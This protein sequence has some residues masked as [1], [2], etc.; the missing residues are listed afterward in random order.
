MTHATFSLTPFPD[1]KLPDI[2]ITG[3][4]LRQR[5]LIE[6]HY[7]VTGDV[8]NIR[9]PPAQ[10][11]PGRKDDLWQATCFEFFIALPNEPPYWEYN[12]SPSGDWNIYRMEAYRRIGFREELSIQN[13]S[14]EVSRQ[15]EHVAV[16]SSTDISPIVSSSETIQ[17]AIT[18]VIQTKDGHKTYWALAHPNLHADFH[19]RESFTLALEA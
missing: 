11:Q 18:S 14:L 4:I 8:A 6:I 16:A 5:S 3:E 12:L 19:L 9:F 7:N 10:S 13:L 2:Q 17:V 1:P 15:R